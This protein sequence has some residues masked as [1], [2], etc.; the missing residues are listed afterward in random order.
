MRDPLELC[1]RSN[2][3]EFLLDNAY[4]TFASLILFTHV[5]F[6]IE[7]ILI[8]VRIPTKKLTKDG[9]MRSARRRPLLG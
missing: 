1:P 6:E 8:E 7:L 3:N 2:G 9:V 5:S 4:P